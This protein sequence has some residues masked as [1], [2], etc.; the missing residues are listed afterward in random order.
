M[1]KILLL[2]LLSLPLVSMTTGVKKT[3]SVYICT[4]PKST[5]YHSNPKCRGLNRCSGEIKA[6]SLADAKEMGRRAC[7]ICYK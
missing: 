6:I 4:G 5:V 7:K 3:S 1:K 2:M